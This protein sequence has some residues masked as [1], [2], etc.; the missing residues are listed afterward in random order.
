MIDLGPIQQRSTQAI[1]FHVKLRDEGRSCAYLRVG[2]QAH[3]ELMRDEEE[4][5][6]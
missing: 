6:A 5:V 3:L 1:H 2:W 4:K